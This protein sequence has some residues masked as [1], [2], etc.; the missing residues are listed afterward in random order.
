MICTL[1][2]FVCFF[3][4]A[5]VFAEF[6]FTCVI[7]LVS[8]LE[9][10]GIISGFMQFYQKTVGPSS[11]KPICHVVRCNAVRAGEVQDVPFA[12]I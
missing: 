2:L 10:D 5:A 4:D 9:Y 7:D 11:P 8:A 1:M 6:S 3:H 12:V